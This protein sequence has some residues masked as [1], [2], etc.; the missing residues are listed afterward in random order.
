MGLFSN[1]GD[2]AVQCAHCAMVPNKKQLATPSEYF[3]IKDLQWF[4]RLRRRLLLL[5]IVLNA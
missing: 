4:R 3:K 5:E 2:P 1:T